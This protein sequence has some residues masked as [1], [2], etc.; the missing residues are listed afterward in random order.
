MAQ[1]RTQFVSKF[2]A[3]AAA[4]GSAVGLGNIWK[5][6]YIVGQNG[7]AAFLLIYL[8]CVLLMG[9]PALITE[10]SVGRIS[11]S[12][13]IDAFYKL[14]GNH[15]WTFIGILG[16]LAA[17]L[18]LSFYLIV[19]GWSLEY[20]VQ[21]ISTLSFQNMS[22]EQLQESFAIFSSGSIRPYIW[23][24]AF[25]VLNIIVIVL[26]VQ[27]GIEKCSEILMPILF[28]VIIFLAIRVY[29]LPNSSAGY[30]FY[31]APDFSKITPSV[32][33]S[34]L[35]QS[36]FS[37]SL[38]LGA[39]L[40]YG[41]YM[42]T[43]NIVHT[44][45]QIALLDSL[46]AILAGLVIFPAVFAYGIEPGE[47]PSLAFVALPAVFSQMPGG[48]VFSFLFFLLLAI[49]ALTSTISLFETCTASVA[50]HFKIKRGWALAVIAVLV[51]IT[52]M[53]CCASL[54]PDLHLTIFG[55]SVFDWFNDISSNFMLPIGGLAM[56]LFLGWAY[57]KK[58]L[59]LALSQFGMP[60]WLFRIYIVFIRIIV[61]LIILLVMLQQFG[62]F[63]F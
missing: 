30:E 28:V 12:N 7:G 50:E 61:P 26:G 53:L 57:P 18:I 5:F 46:I 24:I 1:Q 3:I 41:S 20:I 16:V 29:F 37:L 47:G 32:V 35:G 38:G 58:K 51:V 8:L 10:L 36:F 62:L 63:K 27:K 39:I 13:P 22:A 14:S 43:G 2:G 21:S 45:W 55:K 54:N 49:A 56:S 11:Q 52:S 31:L 42:Q 60:N 40:V 34:A 33:L 19:A 48:I 17:F 4:V 6:P 25:V 44:S 23:A 9:I 59:Q 15:C